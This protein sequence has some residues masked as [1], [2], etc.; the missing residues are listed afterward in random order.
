MRVN[1]WL[2]NTKA[3]IETL[4]PIAGAAAIL[5]LLFGF[6]RSIV[7][8]AMSRT[9]ALEEALHRAEGRIDALEAEVLQCD[10]RNA[11]LVRAMTLAGIDVPPP[12][13]G[14]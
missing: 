9:T 3:A 10:L 5:R 13:T 6:Q 7:D 8:G 1:E 14:A 4:G 11:Q 12:N 2:D